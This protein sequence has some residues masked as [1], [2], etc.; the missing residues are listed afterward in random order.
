MFARFLAFSSLDAASRLSATYTE[1][2]RPQ[3][4]KMYAEAHPKLHRT[5]SGFHATDEVELERLWSPL[6]RMWISRQGCEHRVCSLALLWALDF[7]TKRSGV[8]R[9]TTWTSAKESSEHS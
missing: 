8:E 6:E 4:H 3:I 5:G 1:I 2:P 7:S 9:I